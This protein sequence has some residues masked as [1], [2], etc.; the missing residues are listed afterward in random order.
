MKIVDYQETLW[1]LWSVVLQ[2]IEVI[3]SL[4]RPKTKPASS[5]VNDR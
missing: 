1:I 2:M 5:I 3:S 4:L